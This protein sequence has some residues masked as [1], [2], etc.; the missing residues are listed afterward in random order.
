MKSSAILAFVATAAFAQTPVAAP[1]PVVAPAPAPVSYAAPA[2]AGEVAPLAPLST[3]LLQNHPGAPT[4]IDD[5]LLVPSASAGQKAAGFQWSNPATGEAYV[6]WNNLF[7]AAQY[8]GG[9]AAAA[10]TLASFGFMTPA[11]GL[12]FS[13]A[14]RDSMH[15]NGDANPANNGYKTTWTRSFTQQKLFGSVSLGREEDL[16]FSL[17]HVVPV[18]YNVMVDNGGTVQTR[19]DRQDSVLLNVGLRKYPAAG[20]SGMAWNA[21]VTGGYL[22]DNSMGKDND[23][24]WLGG[25]DGQLGYV[26]ISNGIE[27]LPG[28][29]AYIHYANGYGAASATSTIPDYAVIAGLSPYAAIIVPVYDHLSFKG[30]AR[31]AFE[32]TLIDRQPAKPSDFADHELLTGLT[33]GVG[34]RY[35]HKQGAV[36]AQFGNGL[37]GPAAGGFFGSIALTANLK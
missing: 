33:G 23:M 15:E 27:F 17:R 5:V 7:A 14:V 16:Y 21:S 3:G 2:A 30:G 24:V 28:V 35:E 20:V 32:Q 25:L 26:A 4:G 1:A 19:S 6:L 31:Y 13:V 37:I 10:Q 18:D 12:G 9:G 34:L 29:D 22:Y 11:F 8:T 36:E